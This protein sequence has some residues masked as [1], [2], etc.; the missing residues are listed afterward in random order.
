MEKG[1]MG[2][3]CIEELQRWRG[4]SYRHRIPL[5]RNHPSNEQTVHGRSHGQSWQRYVWGFWGKRRQSV[6]RALLN[7]CFSCDPFVLRLATHP[8]SITG[9]DK[10]SRS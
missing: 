10:D 6:S 5:E 8:E 7:R 4:M 1:T 3:C 2:E 9:V